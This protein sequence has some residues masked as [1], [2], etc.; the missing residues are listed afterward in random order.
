MRILCVEDNCERQKWFANKFV[1]Y[2]LDLCSSVVDATKLTN[3]IKYDIIF[4]D[5]DLGSK[6]TGYDVA[7]II[8]NSINKNTKI[9]VHSNNVVG[10]ENIC[11]ILKH[12]KKIPF[13]NLK[14]L[15]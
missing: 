2:D 1:Q 6:K 4:L 3:S 10:S 5:H 8:Y 13:T 9:I 14:G 15:L 12:A 7:K 11:K